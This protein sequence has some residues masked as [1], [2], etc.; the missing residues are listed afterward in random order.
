MR[1]PR[2]LYLLT[3]PIILLGLG[4][5]LLY[6]IFTPQVSHAADNGILQWPFAPS[7]GPWQIYEGYNSNKSP[8][9]NC[10]SPNCYERYGFDFIIPPPGAASGKTVYSPA[11][12]VVIGTWAAYNNEG[13]CFALALG[14]SI[15]VMVCHVDFYSGTVPSSL[16]RG[17]PVGTVDAAA[18][19]IHMNLYTSVS[20]IAAGNPYLRYPVPFADPWMVGGCDY[21][22]DPNDTPSDYG[23][24]SGQSVPCSNQGGTPTL[25]FSWGSPGTSL[26][27]GI[28]FS[29][30]VTVE[31]RDGLTSA[32][33]YNQSV[34]TDANGTATIQLIGVIPGTY[35]VLIKPQ[36]FLRQAY[37][38]PVTLVAG[39]NTLAFS[40]TNSGTS[41][42][43]GSPTGQ[44]LWVGDIDG[45]NV[46]NS[47]DY[48][49]IVSYFDKSPPPGDVDLDGDGI[50]DGV[51][52]NMWLRSLCYF[53]Y[54]QGE[55]VGAGSR[56]DTPIGQ[57]ATHSASTHGQ[58]SSGPGTI[59]LS[60]SSGSHRVNQSFSVSVLANSAS[61]LLDGADMVIHYDP[62]VLKVTGITPG[63]VF[64]ATSV[65]GN[66]LTTGEINI[67]S[68]ANQ[69]QPVTASGTLATIQF[70]VIGSGQTPVTL[71]FN[72]NSEAH[73][74]MTQD[75]TVAQVLGS[76]YSASYTAGILS[77]PQA[78]SSISQAL[79]AANSGETVLVSPGTYHEL[80]TVPT[81]VILE[82]TN[83]TTTIIDGSYTN[84]TPVVRL[85]NGSIIRN[86][87]IQHSGTTFWD[88]AIWA[89]QGPVTITNTR[90][91]HSSMGIVR[92]C[93]SPP[94]SDTS[95]ISNNLVGHNINT[96][97]L[98]H[99]AQAQV[100]NNTVVNNKLQ[101]ITFEA[102]GGQGASI[103]N[104]LS[105]NQTG[106][107]APSPTML[108]SN[109]LW[110]NGT[111]YGSNTPPGSTDI[112][113]DPLFVSASTSNYNLHAASPAISAD[114][115][116]GA[117]P[118][119]P[120][121]KEPV[122]LNVTQGTQG[123]T[124]T[125]KSTGE[126]GYYVYVLQ[127]N[128]F[129][130]APIDVGNVTSYTF[131]SLPAGA[132]LFAVT[133]YNSKHKES[134]ADYIGATIQ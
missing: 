16:T 34:T 36:G 129:F 7:D 23:Q 8:D 5:G 20:N 130:G 85:G 42:I 121:G 15:Y 13:K 6:H 40:M 41:C 127:S 134:W 12:G 37:P 96:G 87:T 9:H 52:Y 83:E 79:A 50:L 128:G 63:S 95:T 30:P 103:A 51:D 105:N 64:P 122:K 53:G 123:V 14:S 19:H 28:N 117:Y 133:S 1:F 109:L 106:L 21:P 17:Q 108:V 91:L 49:V 90:I 84:N 46:L 3:I 32:D 113:A 44:Q 78:Y 82:G 110:M 69:G 77:V 2:R 81:G 75:G 98:I 4:I 54:G 97:I 89:D 10:N 115:S 47:A 94:C 56:S 125:W 114:G 92:Y 88:A 68:V 35:N 80:L 71:D 101:G 25:T 126:A 31:V 107:T 99:G 18:N 59:S 111:T 120:V 65:L 74:N 24:Y 131:T 100:E 102:V 119:V 132:T 26:W 33:I 27:S 66:N 112:Q 45:N 43:D 60:P 118:F 93:W 11:S 29:R 124:L 48:S 70:Q 38:T 58:A 72:P 104:I 57:A 22:K 86:L 67:S 76:V 39:S 116:L 61:L 73:S 55:V 62:T